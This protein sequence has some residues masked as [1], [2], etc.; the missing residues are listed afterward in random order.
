MFTASTKFHPSGLGGELMLFHHVGI[1]LVHGWLVDPESPEAEVF[2]RVEDYDTAVGLI[3]E[4]D[5]LT[6]GRFVVNEDDSIAASHAGSSSSAGPTS[7]HRHHTNEEL[8]KIEDGIFVSPFQFYFHLYQFLMLAIVI[9]R[10]LD[11]TQSQLTYHGLFHLA[12]VLP[13][14]SLCALFRNSHLSVLYK[15]APRLTPQVSHPTPNQPPVNLSNGG[16]LTNSLVD[17]SSA[18]ESGSESVVI[19]QRGD[20]ALYSLVTDQVFLHEPS[21]VWERL[22][23]VDGG[24]STFVDSNFVRSSPA[25]GDF[26]GHTAEQVSN[27][28]EAET[29][30][31]RE[32]NADECVYMFIYLMHVDLMVFCYSL[33]LA[34]QLQAEEENIARTEYETYLLEDKRRRQALAQQKH[35]PQKK[36][37]KKKGDCVIM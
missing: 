26:A 15:H 1:P 14:D 10:F 8:R 22:E 13:S 19:E 6:S 36:K 5:H 20:S 11:S 32:A 35:R 4:V 25:G 24:W 27:A 9:R 30:P 37:E 21:V 18:L 33:A 7:P 34:R 23:D 29:G 12:T 28:L 31:R 2:S 3:V 16:T 17:P